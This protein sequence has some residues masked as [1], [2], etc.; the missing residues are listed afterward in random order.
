MSA[1]PSFRRLVAVLLLV[2]AVL[3]VIRFAVTPAWT[4]FSNDA[5]R[6]A[7]LGNSIA[8]F[9]RLAA[10]LEENRTRL[11]ALREAGLQSSFILAE[12]TST[13]ASVGLQDR[14]QAA[15][16]SNGGRLIS[17]QVLPEAPVGG[18]IR[19]AVRGRMQ[20]SSDSLQRVLHALESGLPYVV[21]EDLMVLSRQRRSQSKT[22]KQVLL[23]VRLSVVGFVTSDGTGNGEQQG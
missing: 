6:V 16:Q 22:D 14:I 1:N 4:A 19:V 9:E 10:K 7:E 2:L 17:S 18:L 21:I 3:G 13:L 20:L 15:V 11:S 12:A 8:R 23:D 5:E